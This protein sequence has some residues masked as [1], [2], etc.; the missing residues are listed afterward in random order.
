[1]VKTFKK[2][3]ETFQGRNLNTDLDSYIN[4]LNKYGGDL[5]L[6]QLAL[7]C[8]DDCLSLVD[9]EEEGLPA[10]KLLRMVRSWLANHKS[11]DREE[12]MTA[13][14]DMDE[15]SNNLG[16]ANL[17]RASIQ[18]ETL[19]CVLISAAEA[20]EACGAADTLMKRKIT[21]PRFSLKYGAKFAMHFAANAFSYNGVAFTD[22]IKEYR[23]VG[24][25]LAAKWKL[26]RVNNEFEERLNAFLAAGIRNKQDMMELLD[27]LSE[28]D[29]DLE[30]KLQGKKF[31]TALLPGMTFADVEQLYDELFRKK[32]IIMA[33]LK[34][35]AN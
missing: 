33:V 27:L 32:D 4:E 15:I 2:F 28:V 30:V 14:N 3:L 31:K 20:G 9:G 1:M 19:R 21:S 7:Y 10:V 12:I 34:K 18:D 11:V 24:E 17:G 13:V 29:P 26:S 25:T 6:V 5:S 35:R 23:H 22:K 8:A 16:V